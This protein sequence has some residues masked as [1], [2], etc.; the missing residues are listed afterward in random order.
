MPS[1][2]VS[3]NFETST[4]A[5]PKLGGDNKATCSAWVNFD[6]TTNTGG[7]CTI[8][9]QHNVSSVADNGSGDYTINFT[10]AMTDANYC[11]SGTAAEDGSTNTAN[12]P[13]VASRNLAS[14][15]TASSFRFNVTAIDPTSAWSRDATIIMIQVFSN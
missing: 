7:N 10:T 8:R 13:T 15:L 9:G 14:T 4:G 5:I 11:Y 1:A 3:D 12:V 6:G 2:V